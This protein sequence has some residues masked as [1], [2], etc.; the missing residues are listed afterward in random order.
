MYNIQ[1]VDL[2][3]KC[4][5]RFVIEMFKRVISLFCSR[6]SGEVHGRIDMIDCTTFN[7]DKQ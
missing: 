5:I 2:I 7:T 4:N 1:L 3:L 6:V